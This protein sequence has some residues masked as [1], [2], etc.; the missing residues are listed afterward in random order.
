[1]ET[2]RERVSQSEK[3]MR[4]AGETKDRFL[5]M[6]S[7]ELR[8]PLASISFAL[9]AI[10]EHGALPPAVASSLQM[11][12][13]NVGLEARLI[14]ELL[15]VTRIQRGKLNVELELVDVHAILDDVVRMS[16]GEAHTRG[17]E[18]ELALKARAHHVRADPGRLRQVF[19]NLM[20]NAFKHTPA[21]GRVT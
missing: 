20:D 7:H 19:W 21:G 11:I 13:R 6:L 17:I 3:V 10:R 4:D 2:E 8:A 14:D 16:A 18:V 15:D 1:I 12:G 9:A 5:A